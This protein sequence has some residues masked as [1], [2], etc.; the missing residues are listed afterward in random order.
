M[1]EEMMIKLSDLKDPNHVIKVEDHPFSAL[2]PVQIRMLRKIQEQ[3]ISDAAG[4]DTIGCILHGM[5]EGELFNIAR[6]IA[7][8]PAER[9]AS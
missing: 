4:L 5:S 8:F 7:S 9:P 3:I 2:A 6:F 1:R